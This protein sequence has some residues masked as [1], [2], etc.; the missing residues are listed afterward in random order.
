MGYNLY[1]TRA[2]DWVESEGHEITIS[3][4]L[5]LIKLDPDLRLAGD[6][7][8]PQFTVWDGHPDDDESWLDWNEGNITTKNPDD[9]LIAKMVEIAA[10]LDARVQGD[11]G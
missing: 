3:E 7:N 6:G 5:A 9:A 8:G 1:I 10:K 11:D 2:E 4:W